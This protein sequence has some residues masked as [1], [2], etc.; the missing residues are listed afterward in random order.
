MAEPQPLSQAVQA[1]LAV[2]GRSDSNETHGRVAARFTENGLPAFPAV[3]EA[4]T[5]FGGYTLPDHDGGGRFRLLRAKEALRR[6]RKEGENSA[7]PALFRIVLGESE[8]IQARYRMDGHGRIFED[9][10]LIAEGIVPWLEGRC[11]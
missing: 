2:A 11:R 6:L 9:D 4:F 10:T 7:E 1:M 8:T 5:R 3:V